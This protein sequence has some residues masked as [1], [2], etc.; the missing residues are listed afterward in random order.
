MF[1]KARDKAK[2]SKLVTSHGLRHSF[3]THL[4]EKGVPLHVVQEL[5][6]H[7]SIKTTEVSLPISNK[8]RKKLKSPLD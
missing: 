8:F 2:V 7:Y 1:E 5:L 6:G 4:I 3:A